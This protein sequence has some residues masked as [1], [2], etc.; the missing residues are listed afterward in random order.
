M[1]LE[2]D[3]L[4]DAVLNNPTY[5]QIFHAFLKQGHIEE[6][7]ECWLAIQDYKRNP[8]KKKAITIIDGWVTS[9]L[10]NISGPEM[11]ALSGKRA[12]YV[13]LRV[14]AQKMGF[15]KRHWSAGD[16]KA[17]ANLFDAAERALLV[18]MQNAMMNF[19]QTPGG[20]AIAAIIERDKT[21][22]KATIA[23]LNAIG[24]Y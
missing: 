2:F 4:R 16:R 7:L 15:F 6:N 13:A 23:N 17:S 11:R 9:G 10:V 12:A 1:S 18:N 20:Q 24:I 3:V 19:L 8:N 14:D 5:V 22:A 21:R